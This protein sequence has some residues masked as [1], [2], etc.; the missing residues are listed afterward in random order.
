VEAVC[1]LD[2]IWCTRTS[3][4]GVFARAIT[5]D[6]ARWLALTKP[7]THRPS[8]AVWQQ[9]HDSAGGDIDQDRAI[10]V[11]TAQG[12]IVDPEHFRAGY[13]GR[14]QCADESDQGHP[15]YVDGAAL[16]EARARPATDR[17]RDILQ[18]TQQRHGPTSPPLN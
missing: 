8:R 16:R 3:T 9:V 17:Q 11:M 14:W 2:S 4:V 13:R 7:G 6:Q 18:Q 1:Y 5:T 12:E 10:A 15:T